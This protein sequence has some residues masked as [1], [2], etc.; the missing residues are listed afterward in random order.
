MKVLTA[1]ILEATHLELTQ[2]I[3]FPTRDGSTIQISIPD[4]GEQQLWLEA[5][6]EH[7]AEAYDEQDAIYDKL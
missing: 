2:P 1:K 3:P 7:F 6:T 5:S 4:L